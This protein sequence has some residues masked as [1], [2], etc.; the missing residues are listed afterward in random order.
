MT[1]AYL[2]N[3]FKHGHLKPLLGRTYS[4]GEVP[5][6]HTNIMQSSGA[7]GRVTIKIRQ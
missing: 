3:G 1:D 5:D 6:A 4:L 7:C 2:Q